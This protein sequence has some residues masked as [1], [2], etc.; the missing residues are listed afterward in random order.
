MTF[1][2]AQNFPRERAK[3]CNNQVVDNFFKLLE[4]KINELGLQRKP[5]HIFN[6]DETGFMASKGVRKVF[7]RVGAKNPHSIANNNQKTSYTVQVSLRYN[8][9][10][11]L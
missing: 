1:R 8:H 5:T 9:V 6:V 4:K 2:V 7:C 11:A 3:A 10:I